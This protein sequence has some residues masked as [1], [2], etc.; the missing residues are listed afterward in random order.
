MKIV[1]PV[2]ID[3]VLMCVFVIK[4]IIGELYPKNGQ[5]RTARLKWD[6]WPLESRRITT[7]TTK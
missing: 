5:T 2:R 4:G 1:I 7:V 3:H 6:D